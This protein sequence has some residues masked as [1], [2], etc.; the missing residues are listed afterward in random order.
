MLVVDSN[1]MLCLTAEEV[2]ELSGDKLKNSDAFLTFASSIHL[3]EDV[4]LEAA[5]MRF[6]I[7][8]TKDVFNVV[9]HD[10]LP[11]CLDI[12]KMHQFDYVGIRIT[13]IGDYC[14][15]AIN[16]RL[17]T[18][19]GLPETGF[20][21][22]Q[23][24]S[25]EIAPDIFLAYCRGLLLEISDQVL[26][27][28]DEYE[29]VLLSP[30]EVEQY[31]IYGGNSSAHACAA[32]A[33][34]GSGCVGNASACAANA[35]AGTGCAANASACAA[36]A[37]VGSACAANASGCVN[38]ASVVGACGQNYTG[39]YGKVGVAGACGGNAGVCAGNGSVVSGC[40]VNASACAGNV[41][42]VTG[43]AANASACGGKASGV[44]IANTACAGKA[45]G[46]DLGILPCAGDVCP[47]NI[48]PFL[49]SC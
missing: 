1:R 12:K 11:K 21:G 29:E 10:L 36:N 37:S 2:V 7:D 15:T 18:F 43:C 32:N 23:V 30:D 13:G 5:E 35:G 19:D 48:I 45:C 16:G 49:P 3:S 24:L 31:G 17:A 26:E 39:C 33:S 28:D 42:A 46:V 40:A 20:T 4:I 14:L 27:E 6:Q 25:F 34:A 44:G 22:E 38:N 8:T 41:S 9:I 47:V